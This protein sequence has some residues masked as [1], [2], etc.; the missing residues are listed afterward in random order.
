MRS[1]AA[2]R[3]F[4]LLS[5]LFVPTVIY[6]QNVTVSGTVNFASL[7]GGTDDA[8]HTANGVFTVNGNL[9]VNGTINC[10][11]DGAGANSACSMQFVVGGGL[12]LNAGSQIFAE[13]RTKA[14][15]GG[16]I[17][18]TVGGDAVVHGLTVSLPGALVSSAKTNA[19]N[20]AHGGDITFNVG[21]VY[22]QELGSIISSAANDASAG[23]I[24]IT[25][26]GPATIGGFIFAGPS[27][28]LGSSIYTDAILTGGGGHVVGGAITIKSLT[29]SEPGVVV[30]QFAIVAS[31]GSDGG[32]NTVDVEGCNVQING[33]VAAITHKSNNARVVVR[34]G[35]TLTVDGSNLD[36]SGL[37]HFGK[38]RG[39]SYG[40]G[41]ATN[42]VDVYAAKDISIIGPS[43]GSPYFVVTANPG[44]KG[45][46]GS[47]NVISTGG[48]VTASGN[49]FAA[50]GTNKD[51]NGGNISVS[52][53][54]NVTL[55][56]A[57]VI[58]AGGTTGSNRG[59][60]HITARSYSGA[61]NWIAGV[62]D[63]RPVGSTSGVPTAQQ[64]TIALTYC[65]T[66]ST[67]G[68]SFPTNGSPVGVF[69]TT[70]QTCSPAAPS[71]PAGE[72]LPT[73]NTPPV[74]DDTSATTNEDNSVTVTMTATD[75]DGNSM[76]FS[77]VTPP[78]HG[79]LGPIFNQTPTSAQ[80]TYTPNANYNGSDSFT[81]QADDGQGGT[82]TGVVTI[83]IN[84]VN[85]PPTF[86]LG[87]NPVSSNEDIGP[88]S[89]ANYASSISPGPT[90]DE[91]S[92]TVTFTVNNDNNALFS[93]QPA[94][95]SS[96]TLTYTSA[97]NAN[98]SAN[99][100]VVAHDNGGTANGGNDTST[101]HNFN[102]VINAVNDAP[103]FTKGADQT[104]LEDSGAHTVSGWATGISAGPAD[105]SGQ[106]VTFNVSNDNNALFSAQ[107]AVASDG[108][109]TFTSAAN[110]NGTATV[111]VTAHDNGG[112]ANGG[113]DTSAPQTFTISVTAVN[114]AP[115][116]TSGGDVTVLEDSGAYSAAWATAISAGPADESG[117]TVTFNASNDNNA[118]FSVQPSVS[119]SGALT[120]TPAADA[121]GTAT[122]T[123]TAQD[124]GGTANGGVDTSASQTFTITVTA[125]NDAP[126]F[127]KGADQTSLEDGGPQTVVGW[128]TA[129]SAGPANES[130]QTVT[131]NVS[132]DNNALFSAQPA[133]SSNGTLTYTAA[134]N[135]NGT[136]TV[137]IAAHDDGGTANGGVDTSAPQTF[138]IT[139]TAVND[140]PSF[141]KGADQT[142]LEDSG[143]HTVTGWATAISPGP[144]DESSQ[145]VSFTVTNDNNALF[146]AQP[147]VDASG[148]LTFT[149]AADAFGTATVTVTA[150]DDGGTAN[151]GVD[152]SAPQTF[153]ITVTAV[154]DAPSF[155]K[156]ADQTSLEDGGPQT[157]VGWATAIS[158]GPANESGQTVTFTSTNDNNA[159]FSA[160][161]AV[162][163]N[164]T[165]TYTAASNVN[166]TATVIVTAHDNGGTANGGVDTSAPQTFTI[167]ITAVNDAPSFTK[168]ADQTVLEDSGPHT[169]TGWA[170][171]I[172]PGPADESSQTVS[173]TVTNDNNALFSAQPAV[174]ASGNLTF[175]TAA[176]AFGSATVTVVAHDNGGTANGGVDTSAGQTFLI[177]VTGVNDAPS[178]VK[179]PDVT[180]ASNAG[181][182]TF[183][184]WATSISAGPANESGQTV[185]FNV[186]NDNNAVFTAQPAVSSTGTLTFTTASAAPTTT[187]HLS[188]AAQDN[189]GT[190]NGGVD[191]SAAQTFNINVTHANQP[192]VANADSYDA[193]GNTELVVGTSSTQPASLVVAVGSVLANDTDPDGDPLTATLG[194][195]T[196]GA[197][198]TVNSD[199]TFRY[200]PPAGFTGNDTFTY[201]A[202]DGQGH[203]SNG[204]V[205][206]H[207]IKRVLYVSNSAGGSTG[208]VD[209]PFSTLAAAQ[210]AATTND[211]VYVFVGN[212]NTTNQAA[213]FALSHDGERLIGEGVA[214]NAAGTY[215]G[216]SNPQLRAAGSRPKIT[217]GAGD[218]VTV[219]KSPVAVLTNAEVSGVDILSPSVNGV[220]VNTVTGMVMSSVQ[221]F[222]PGRNGVKGS[223]VVNF[224]FTNGVVSGTGSNAG[225]SAFAFDTAIVGNE[226]NLS[227][228]VTISNNTITNPFTHGVHIQNFAGTITSLALS[229]N[230]IT[231]TASTATST[232]NAIQVI[233]FGSAAGAASVQAGT[234]QNN[235][236]TGFPSGG[237]ILLQGGNATSAVAPSANLGVANDNTKLISITGNHISG[238]SA[239]A[240]MNTNAIL[241]S[242]G[243]VGSAN[244]DISSNGTNASPIANLNGAAVAFS[245]SGSNSGSVTITNNFLSPSNILGSQGIAVVAATQFAATDAPDVRATISGNSVS[246]V[247]GN[248]IFVQVRQCNGSIEAKVQNNT[249][250]TPLGA[251]RHG[252]R[253]ESGGTVGNTNVCLNI[254]GNTSSGNGT[255]T[256]IGLRKQGTNAAVN[257]FGVNG[258]VATASPAV[259]AYV[260]LLNPAGGGTQLIS[261]TSGFSNCSL[262]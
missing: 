94:I 134:P 121:N 188:V 72:T 245:M 144:A 98:G 42:R 226:N 176:D 3:F 162:A 186:S 148:N 91:S 256:G 73:C 18:F 234:I 132:N 45:D 17:S 250:A 235:T 9:T 147:A 208:R 151:G 84:P 248:G 202:N 113:V 185:S 133:V 213:G 79:N 59:G 149:T 242:I 115:S 33:L 41:A 204:T 179:G 161:P 87:A 142:V 95:S 62:G 259:E 30:S 7:D 46:G 24:S 246:N 233:E 155:T 173:F 171:A 260:T 163:S 157:V 11:D 168:G 103:S 8:D 190:A 150:H 126:S 196:A 116:F 138:T 110:A 137:T 123:V 97:P 247:D 166:G 136:A 51:Q 56:G 201:V 43:T 167:T 257:V 70:A 10:N 169:V 195:S 101:T 180:V 19:G 85:D 172:S 27:R 215:N 22:T 220:Q 74:A 52:A 67:S 105:E 209:S 92:Q 143:P 80:V 81:F 5:L 214:L 181:P 47:I 76:T 165:L 20:P 28:T 153:T 68:T 238:A 135:A 205:T 39:D 26:N 12:T 182:Q 253:V 175:T 198:V 69:P 218:G 159:L 164:G 15:N 66:L 156:G 4:V 249:V 189:G 58:A 244:A 63:V 82:D 170:T 206:I 6:A 258:M 241:V 117:Q 254:T 89:L 229:N 38:L 60:G 16:N 53:K 31:Q 200:L 232:G 261:A 48:V 129:I 127:T 251:G 125:V 88:Q 65:T 61:L 217:N 223:A 44:D 99:V 83:T 34:S 237:G 78:A 197:V 140:A 37:L 114:D 36:G 128:A 199:G 145:T 152:T 243:G 13:N 102:I 2:A 14:G 239:A 118:L 177:N 32:G 96:G 90:A 230:I 108:T 211:T 131:F 111:T 224:S 93:V 240:K 216:A 106:T 210:A 104:V 122:V 49:A 231:S 71:L 222:T 57:S 252:I 100:T 109:L 192:P 174:D 236:I 227:G 146:S 225:D 75:A 23:A 228:T 184:N 25:S 21:G 119:S 50:T 55:S 187:V 255:A 183:P 141:T 212:G 160:Q 130:G 35:T 107:P 1:H 154:N 112:T 77:I 221:I 86:N 124:N 219:Q 193:V 158:A 29:H 139:I 178:F 64:G 54:G 40:D 191:T 120:F 262:P 194:T 207:V 203:N